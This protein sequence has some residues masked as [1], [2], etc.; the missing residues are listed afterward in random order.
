VRWITNHRLVEIAYL[1]LDTAFAIGDRT[2]IA[3]VTVAANPDGWAF[4]D[5]RREV[6]ISKPLIEARRI[7]ANVSVRRPRHFQVARLMEDGETL[8]GRDRFHIDFLSDKG[9]L[10]IA[11]AYSRFKA[12]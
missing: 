9:P 10:G 6:R 2:K 8:V 12:A 3:Q 11:A 4:W 5:V 7:P 1:N